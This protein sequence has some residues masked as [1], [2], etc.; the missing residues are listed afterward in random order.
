MAREGVSHLRLRNRKLLSHFLRAINLLR[1]LFRASPFRHVVSG[2]EMKP[3][4]IF[5]L[6]TFCQVHSLPYHYGK[7]RYRL[8][9]ST[10]T[11]RLSPSISFGLSEAALSK[12][13]K[14]RQVNFKLFSTL[15]I[16]LQYCQKYFCQN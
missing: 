15:L 6:L 5:L 11:S 13:R 7:N 14:D 8:T 3:L 16:W 1:F 12:Y 2:R 9:R 4:L 10:S